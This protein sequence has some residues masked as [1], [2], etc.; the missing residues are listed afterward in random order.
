MT[1]CQG[2]PLY[3]SPPTDWSALY[4][5]LK[6]VQGINVVVSGKKKTIVTLDLQLYVKCMQLRKYEE[7]KDNYVFRLGE[8]HT[9]FAMLKV[10]GKY[11]E[12]SGLDTLF[13]EA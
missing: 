3:P 13:V 6:M 9:V 7:I 2:L 4:T 8:L 12:S 10:L 5:C 1:E 11:I